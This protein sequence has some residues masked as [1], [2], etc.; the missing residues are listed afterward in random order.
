M[1]VLPGIHHVTAICGDPQRN[2]DFYVDLLGLRLVKKTVNFDDP[3]TYHLYYGDGVGSPGTIMT[4]FAWIGIPPMMSA[5]GRQ[6][7]GQI[8]ATS[9]SVT[10]QSFNYWIDR[11]AAAAVDFDAD[12][13]RFGGHVITF[14]DP[15]GL[16]LEIV[17][18]RAGAVRAP[19]VEGPVPIEHAIRGFA[20]ATLCLSGYENTAG[21]LTRTLGFHE[22]GREG[23]RFRFRI[24]DGD[25][26]AMIDLHCAPEEHPGRMGIGVVHHIA[27]RAPS[28]EDQ[29]RWRTVI[30]EAGYD[31][32]PVLD[33]EY[34]QS[35]YF[36]EPGGVLFEIATDPPGFT[37][38]ESRDSLGTALKLPPWLEPRRDRIQARLPDLH[39]PISVAR[40]ASPFSE[41]P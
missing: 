10:A 37:V 2:I 16:P 41:T 33:R 19:W 8:S 5:Q 18:H 36:R 13:S 11:F 20:G 3:G 26:A 29:L 24:G 30:A 31:V 7:P 28:P 40:T 27:W 21:M 15:D 35:I 23:S 22:V 12:E 39:V 6:G 4:F 14:R 34:F 32:T 38:D 17:A 9:F 25:D 1:T